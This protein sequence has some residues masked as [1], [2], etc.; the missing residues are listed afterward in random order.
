MSV[1]NNA[2]IS[3]KLTAAFG[4]LLV[5]I[6]VNAGVIFKLI[7]EMDKATNEITEN[8]LPS[9]I[10]VNALKNSI[11]DFRRY[12]L[13]HILSQDAADISAMDREIDK[14]RA[15]LADD[16]KAYEVLISSA[17]EQGIYNGY[18]EHLRRYFEISNRSLEMSRS[19]QNVEAY[20]IQVTDGRKLFDDIIQDLDRLVK[21]NN[22]SAGVA[23]KHQE[24]MAGLA[25]IGLG[26]AVV[27]FIV[28]AIGLGSL[29]N[30]ILAVP[31][32]D[33]THAM[34]RLANGDLSVEIPARGR[35]DEIGQMAQAVEVFR[36]NAQRAERFAAEDKR[37]QAE[38]DRRV[39]ALRTL[40]TDFDTTVSGVLDVVSRAAGTMETTAR[41]MTSTA[42][43]SNQQATEVASATE[44]ASA[45]VQTVAS[46]SEELS[47]SINEI[48]RQVEQSILISRAASQDAERTTTIVQSLA[49]AS[50]R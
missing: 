8:W 28:L 21:L 42:Q 7:S 33:M 5:I 13:G 30:R 2:K 39:E 38:R 32:A 9:V 18:K 50:G 15:V 29:M 1:I 36:E 12:E 10:A 25:R 45:S 26:V 34:K 11:L 49:D 16:Q 37:Q 27:I 31:I 4:I 43:Q 48:G 19:N 47:S 35:G 14:V 20:K 41:S 44:E 40:T 22:D 46:A 6:I 17:E 3:S 24:D 23:S